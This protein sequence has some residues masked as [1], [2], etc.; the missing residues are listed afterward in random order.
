MDPEKLQAIIDWLIDG[1][2]SAAQ[3][4]QVMAEL[5]ERLTACG[6]PLARAAVLVRTLHPQFM[7]RRFSWRPGQGVEVGT[8]PHET[9]LGPTFLDSPV[10]RVYETGAPLRRRLA[11]PGCPRDFPL[12]HELA[13][14]GMTDY[15]ALPL[16]FSN[17][18]VHV[19]SWSTKQPGGFT[20]AQTAAIVAVT[21]P[22]ARVS[23][24]RA[25]RRTAVNLL[26]TYVGNNAGERILAGQI[27]RG[28]TQAI[29]AAIWLSD[30]RGFT[31]LADRL[32]S[33]QLIDVLNR[34]FD[35]QVPPI[36]EHGGE[37]LKFMGDGLLAIFRAARDGPELGAAC[38]GALAAARQARTNVAETDTELAVPRFGL[39]LHVG[40]VLYG[41]IGSG[42]RL[43]FTCIGPAVNLA[44]RLEK[45]AAGLGRTV[46]VSADFSR[47]CGAAL[48][49]IGEFP[50]RGFRTAQWVFGLPEE[51]ASSPGGDP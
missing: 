42:T 20:D 26:N 15:F 46:V 31:Q 27:R 23:E 35:C 41:N 2:S 1:A 43:D 5:A 18:E 12:L 29:H 16:R 50:I 51:A 13:A 45:L 34:Y 3:P 25:L 32:P 30:M 39:A 7:G 40:E 22:L 47:H 44:A 14:E 28:E 8:A 37:V 4:E 17:G 36:Q 49:P 24:V 38:A 10:R 6:L 21:V 9:L 11:D 33:Q 19:A 48:A